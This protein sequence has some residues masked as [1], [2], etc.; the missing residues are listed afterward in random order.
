MQPRITR[1]YLAVPAH[2]ER[3]V[4]SAALSDAD[5]VF[6]DLEDAVPP[7]SKADALRAAVLALSTLDW[8]TKTVTVRVNTVASG[9]IE[10]EIDTLG[11]LPRLDG[12][13]VPKT[14]SAAELAALEAR[15]DGIRRDSGRA[16][17]EL[18]PLI[19]TARGLVNVEAIAC[20]GKRVAALHF[21]V[22]DFAASIGMRSSEVGGTP[23]GYTHVAKQPDD[24][25]RET[26]LD[27][28]VYPMMRI[29]VAARAFGL[30][31]IDGPCGAFRDL[32]LTAAWARKAASMGFDG[33][34]VIHPSQIEPTRAAFMPTD[35]ELAFATRVIEAM[36][37]AQ[38]SG[39][40]AVSVDGKM[41]DYANL[42]M[43][44]R[45]VGLAARR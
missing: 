41:I 30:R 12:L 3:M 45:I 24:S 29:L 31:A 34:Q 13:I 36:A 42:R 37:A 2:R 22:G 17:L 5:A 25:Y 9:L 15:L 35:E 28:A 39:L 38:A 27:I 20:A 44:E 10:N 1:T 43:A 19:E 14:E 33:K 32:R 23:A 8:G 21:G 40:G 16:P 4:A 18:E 6:I 26:P 7:A 11:A